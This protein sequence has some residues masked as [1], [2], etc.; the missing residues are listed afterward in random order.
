MAIWKQ[1]TIYSGETDIWYHQPLYQVIIGLAHQREITGVTV[2][3]AIAGYGKHGVFR[4]LDSIDPVSESSAL[5]IVIT[6][7]DRADRLD[8]FIISI[9]EMITDKFVTYCDIQILEN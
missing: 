4:T 7:I 6:I 5:P 9:R 3:R 8:N 2:T 1:L